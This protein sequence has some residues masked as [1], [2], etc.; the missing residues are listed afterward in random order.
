MQIV[1]EEPDYLLLSRQDTHT[2]KNW[3]VR[4]VLVK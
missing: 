4:L 2:F 1:W 3:L